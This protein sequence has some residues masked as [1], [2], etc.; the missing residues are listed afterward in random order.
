MP[1][2][3]YHQTDIDDYDVH[4]LDAHSLYGTMQT[5]A[6]H[7]WFE[8]NDKRTMIIERSSFA[9]L[10]KFGSRWLGD[11][12]SDYKYMGFS[13]TSV[14]MQNIIG[15]PLAGADICGFNGD[16]DADLCTRWYGVGAFYP[17]SRNHNHLD[18]K[19]QEPYLFTDE[20]KTSSLKYIDI[21]KEAMQIKLAL[22][23]YYYT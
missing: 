6:T 14:M 2:D 19:S 13:V 12:F 7:E 20:Y 21:I 9:G 1:L 4:E 18:S 3:A 10:G 22:V 15:I 17:F 8:A 5:K 23:P 11:N 16:T